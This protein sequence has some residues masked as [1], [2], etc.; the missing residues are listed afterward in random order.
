M[1]RHCWL[2]WEGGHACLQKLC[3]CYARHT[4]APCSS[5][6]VC[7]GALLPAALQHRRQSPAAAQHALHCVQQTD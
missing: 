1:L 5:A 3:G 7:W 6:N 4:L 2:S